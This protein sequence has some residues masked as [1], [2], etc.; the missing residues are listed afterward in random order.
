MKKFEQLTSRMAKSEIS[1]HLDGKEAASLTGPEISE[2]I[3]ALL[4]LG[5]P[6]ATEKQAKFVL[7][8][9]DDIEGLELNVALATVE[10]EDIDEMTM[11]QASVLINDLIEKRD[12]IPRPAS[13]KQL[14]LIKKKIEQLETTVEDVCKLVGAKTLEE[15]TGGRKG[16]ASTLIT[17]LINKTGGPRRGR[18]GGKGKGKAK[19]K[20]KG[21]GKAKGGSAKAKGKGKS[22]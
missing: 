11:E 22:K 21:K 14:N 6:P 3:K 2:V 10:L 5:S 19:G 7:S 16:T 18:R 15:L 4:E 13:D 9:V 12:E 20:P 8:L 1:E 17:E